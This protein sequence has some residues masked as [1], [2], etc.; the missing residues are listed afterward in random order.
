MQQFWLYLYG[1]FVSIMVHIASSANINPVNDFL[2]LGGVSDGVLVLL[3][4]ALVFSSIGGLVVAAILKRLDNIVKEY[5]GATANMVTALLCSILFPMKFTLTVFILV[6]L[7]LLFLGI[8]L[9]ENKKTK[10][11]DLETSSDV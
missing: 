8:Y 5:S 4:M 6:A 3:V 2:S 7:V 10:H 9:Y 11:V 1:L